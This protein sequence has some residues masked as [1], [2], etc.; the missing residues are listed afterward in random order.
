MAYE[1]LARKWR[2][3]QFS[4]VVGQNHVTT[5][6]QNAIRTNRIAHAYLFTGPRGIG[7]TSLA[8]IFAKAL[9]CIEGPTVTPCDRCDS[10]IEIAAG[11]NLDVL[12]I[13]GASNT[14]V[15]QVRDL[16]DNVRYAP[17]RGKFKIYIIDEVHMLST[18]AFNAL[19]KTLEEPPPHVKFMFATT[20]V[21]KILPTILSRCQRFDL[22][23]I[24]TSQ[25][26]ERL[27]LIAREEKIAIEADA[28]L[29]IARGAEGGL[30]DAESALDQLIAFKGSAIVE[31]DVLAVFGLAARQALEDLAEAVLHSDIPCILRSVS[32]LDEAGKDMQRAVI[33]LLEHFRNLLLALYAPESLAQLDL[34]ETQ[35]PTCKRQAAMT[36]A[37]RLLRIIEILMQAE[38][39][40]KYALSRR[41]L[42]ETALIR[43][44]RAAAAISLDDLIARV[45]A[46]RQGLPAPAT[47]PAEPATGDAP[48][49]Y[50]ASSGALPQVRENSAPVAAPAAEL[51]ALQR[52]WRDLVERI[53]AIDPLA[54]GSLIDARP[55][56]VEGATVRIGLEPEYAAEIKKLESRRTQMAVQ[57]VLSEALNRRVVVQFF[58][59]DQPFAQPPRTEPAPPAAAPA[60]LPPAPK[61]RTKDGKRRTREE[62]MADPVVRKTLETF[63]GSIVEIRD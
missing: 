48:A 54:R 15:D 44:A 38:D 55:A 16:R 50:P 30:R 60:P 11:R 52:G 8:R 35:I 22:R 6:L 49:I 2:P 21:Q 5:T 31:A 19:L 63:N 42:V 41:T 43:C 33:E 17:T 40:I 32:G 26:V 61:T 58:A 10:C 47:P 36:D 12:E 59:A 28:L 27:A 23:R 51:A 25:I 14:G 13:D 46:W 34:A 7:K 1:V 57:Q 53:C 62:W 37:D 3:Q 39:R 24:A 4:D 45:N 20:E 56:A 9:N 18:P 29:A